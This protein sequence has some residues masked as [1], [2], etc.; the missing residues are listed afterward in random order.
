[1]KA[2]VLLS[3]GPR[4]KDWSV[5]NDRFFHSHSTANSDNLEG[6]RKAANQQMVGWQAC[7]TGYQFEIREV[8]YLDLAYRSFL[9]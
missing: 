6:Q 7:L 3:K 9:E 5:M 8:N 1:M 4:A 2:I